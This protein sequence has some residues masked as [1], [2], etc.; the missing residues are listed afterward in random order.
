MYPGRKCLGK[1]ST[2]NRQEHQMKETERLEKMHSG[3]GSKGSAEELRL[4]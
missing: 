4:S 1:I 3:I 2:R